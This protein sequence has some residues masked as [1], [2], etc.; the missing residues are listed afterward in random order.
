MSKH[1]TYPA[2]TGA[3]THCPLLLVSISSSACNTFC[4]AMPLLCPPL[5]LSI[6]KTPST[7]DT[8]CNQAE[9]HWQGCAGAS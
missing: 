3:L 2:Q 4:F 6:C 9:I 5:L 7:G 8:A 1:S